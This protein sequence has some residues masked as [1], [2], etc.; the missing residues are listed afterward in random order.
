MTNGMPCWKTLGMAGLLWLC[1]CIVPASAQGT[2]YMAL[3]NW[4]GRPG[5]AQTPPTV[6]AE[7]T[8]DG[9]AAVSATVNLEGTTQGL[10]LTL[11]EPVD[12]SDVE[13]ITFRFRQN[14]Y[15]KA[16]WGNLAIRYP[17]RRN[18]LTIPFRYGAPGEWTPVTI[19]LDWTTLRPS[20][21]NAV[22][23]FPGKAATL[24]F[25]LYRHL[26]K[27]GESI[28]VADLQF[29]RRVAGALKPVR[30]SYRSRPSSGDAS[31]T[32]LTDG[33]LEKAEQAVY[34]EYT[35]NPDVVF[36]FGAPHLVESL[37]V[38][39][40]ATPNT[41]ID[42]MDVYSSDDGE[43]FQLAAHIP[44][45]TTGGAEKQYVFEAKGLNLVCR[46]L[47]LVLDRNR[48]D[49]VITFGEVSFT[50]RR[51]TPEELKK[52]S[53]T[54]YD[55]GPSLPPMT[56]KDYLVVDDGRNSF[57][58]HR[59]TGVVCEVVRDGRKV[60]ERMVRDT[61][62]FD[63]KAS[64]KA[65][66]FRNRVLALRSEGG[67][68]IVDY[69]VPGMEKIRFQAT[70]R[71]DRQGNFVSSLQCTSQL[72]ERRFLFTPLRVFIPQALRNGG[73][74]ETWGSAHYLIHAGA[75]E[76][77]TPLPVDACAVMSFE[78]PSANLTLLH[79]RLRYNGRFTHIGVGAAT[80]SSS[81]PKN[82]VLLPNGWQLGDGIFLLDEPGK[83]VSVENYLTVAPGTLVEA[84]DAYLAIPEVAE[85]RGR[86]R[87]APWVS[88]MRLRVSQGWYGLFGNQLERRL[89]AFQ[90]LIRDG[91][92]LCLLI[93][94][95]FPWG[96]FPTSGEVT[97]FFGGHRSMDNLLERDARLRALSPDVKIVHYTWVSSVSP[98]SKVYQKHPDW[99][100]DKD[101]QGRKINYF[102]S[103]HTNYYRLVGIPESA[104]DILQAI[105]AFIRATK[106]D[107]WY[108]DGGG[109]PGCLDLYNMRMDAPDA[110]Q[111]VTERMRAKLQAENPDSCLFFNNPEN[112]MADFG[113]L[114]SHA[115]ALT[116]H[117][118]DGASWMYKFK[119]WQRHDPDFT[120]L[121]IYWNPR[122][123][124]GILQYTVGTGLGLVVSDNAPAFVPYFSAQTQSRLARLV[125]ASVEPNCRFARGETLEVMPLSF[126]D[127][128]WLFMKSNQDTPQSRKVS[129]A[130]AALGLRDGLPVYN[131]CLTIRYP[132]PPHAKRGEP[133]R[134]SDY[135]RFRWDSDFIAVP[136]F[137]G[138]AALTKRLEKTFDF[139]PNELKLWMVTQ[140]PAL[141]YSVDSMR[142]QLWLS[143]T[144][145]VKMTGTMNDDATRL[146]VAS[147]R[148]AAEI[149]VMIPDGRRAVAAQV[150][151][152]D[153]PFEPFFAGG[154]RFALLAVPQ[155]ECSVMLR[156]APLKGTAGQVELSAN[157]ASGALRI[158]ARR[159]G[160]L[161]TDVP[162]TLQVMQ[163]EIPVWR[164]DSQGAAQTVAL[165]PGTTA[166]EYTL[167]A[168]DP[169]GRALGKAVFRL[170][171]GKP[172]TPPM[173]R[174]ATPPTERSCSALS[175]PRPHPERGLEVLGRA[176]CRTQGCGEV[177]A[178][179]AVP[180]LRITTP[181]VMDTPYN[182]LGTALELK[183]RRYLKVRFKGNFHRFNGFSN[184]SPRNLLT[185]NFSSVNAFFGLTM[186]FG[187]PR[188]YVFR[189]LAGCGFATE[190]R[191][192][193]EPAG[194]GTQKPADRIVNLSEFAV[195]TRPAEE[196]WFDLAALG[197]PSDWDGRLWLGAF[198]QNATPAR[199]WE[200]ELLESRDQ[201]PKGA[202]AARIWPLKGGAP[203]KKIGIRV[204]MTQT[205]P[206]IDGKGDDAAW[207][208]AAVVE[209]LTALGNPLVGAPPTRI[210]LLRDNRNLYM[211]A[212]LSAVHDSGFSV[213]PGLFLDKQDSLELYLRSGDSPTAFVQYIFG[214]TPQCYAQYNSRHRKDGGAGAVIRQLAQPAFKTV[215]TK[216]MM[217]IEAAI[218]L[219][220]LGRPSA[221]TAFNITRNSI[222]NGLGRHYTLAPGRAYYN[223]D[224]YEM[225]WK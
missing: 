62:L 28:A 222:E 29:H 7:K 23:A 42:A 192:S 163:G 209:G 161:S 85:F 199:D 58:V 37:A 108:L 50:G 39:A 38:G 45:R 194:W 208:G 219:A 218:P 19:P 142:T 31:G 146:Q 46:H 81:V 132:L 32:T 150:N 92:I 94:S 73:R 137:L 54:A 211:L 131:W 3:E 190:K 56:P 36:D 152:K 169:A 6:A 89:A 103:S 223:L 200:I 75:D 202:A 8:P 213:R 154:A 118:P 138:S 167:L 10:L 212:E 181:A 134:E 124:R 126:G 174:D 214:G 110:W 17:D 63:G 20:V 122:T 97:N 59:A 78:A 166:G 125:N 74:Y 11:R 55:L 2:G 82:T 172:V 159:T 104:D 204:P 155:G 48:V 14:G 80:S 203:V 130:P 153:V 88:K 175:A 182:L 91:N 27:P 141:V 1:A 156:H 112:P 5:K 127:S 44:N 70:Y 207:R 76:I 47:R 119:L 196:L 193:H 133:E 33:R 114:E 215:A 217:T 113:I 170:A 183:T 116:A 165:P 99:F 106:T 179:P 57:A 24:F 65:D 147:A 210:R 158:Q 21:K 173:P 117:W 139:Q 60:A 197:A 30:Y 41:N 129:F 143:D 128:G 191:L 72:N 162:I 22:R 18:G 93:D 9:K 205:A 53:Q 34:K 102:G 149:L 69:A 71:F 185:V 77:S 216:R 87:R 140:A 171:A 86:I 145:G 123:E 220:E 187:S 168:L 177:N 206:V 61:E 178:D 12:L 184:R 40:V 105:P 176:F 25:N 13:S 120:P 121:Y 26:D 100:M 109:S 43:H 107:G 79:H 4:S 67:R 111:R 186:D 16:G 90:S 51:A 115:G 188:G 201:L 148:R 180:S 195:G 15:A 66:G 189:T 136:R 84:F 64:V 198:W 98:A 52:A 151:G 49:Q 96:D 83:T 135:R 221:A 225:L 164:G 224:H 144:L 95:N 68:A 157:A 35:D 160:G 101:A